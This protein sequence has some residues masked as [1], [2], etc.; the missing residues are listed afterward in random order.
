MVITSQADQEVYG[1]YKT[2]KDLKKVNDPALTKIEWS[3]GDSWEYRGQ[4][5]FKIPKDYEFAEYKKDGKVVKY[6]KGYGG[7]VSLSK[8][9]A[10]MI[11]TSLNDQEVYGPSKTF[12][13]LKPSNEPALHHVE[14]E[15]GETWGYRG[16]SVFRIPRYYDVAAYKK[17]GSVASFGSNMYSATY[18]NLTNGMHVVYLTS[19][20][21]QD[22]YG[23]YRL[24]KKPVVSKTPA[25]GKMSLES[26]ESIV[27][28]DKKAI[29]IVP[30]SHQ[31]AWYDSR[32]KKGKVSNCWGNEYRIDKRAVYISNTSDS[33]TTLYGPYKYFP[34]NEEGTN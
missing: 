23:P 1:P 18:E 26:G 32:G 16:G 11:L 21:D 25:L 9:G 6:D 4:G 3:E 31:Y 12:K 7:T 27:I 8:T 2:F 15:E 14:W 10:V 33:M 20:E 29:F 22:V 28:K 17:D 13:G 24:F 19:R 5:E 30:G 34:Y